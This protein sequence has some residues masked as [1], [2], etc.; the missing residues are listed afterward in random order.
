MEL[1]TVIIS[2]DIVTAGIN[3][4]TSLL[5]I[6]NTDM[7]RVSDSGSIDK[8]LNNISCGVHVWGCTLCEPHLNFTVVNTTQYSRGQA[9]GRSGPKLLPH[10]SQKESPPSNK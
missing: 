8:L 10:S 9:R 6:S 3:Y 7:S 2:N 5:L 1:I 4:C